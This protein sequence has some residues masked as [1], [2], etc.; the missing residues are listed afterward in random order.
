MGLPEINIEF[1]GKAVSAIL[2]SAMGIVSLILRDDTSTFDS[3]EYK[4]I[5]EIKGNDWSPENTDFIKL[6]MKGTPKKVICE[7]VGTEATDFN[8]AL[9]RLG[10]K[11]WNYLAIPE[12]LSTEVPDIET[13]IKAKRENEK[14]TFKAV[15]PN[16]EADHEGII[17]FATDDIQVGARTY[18]TEEYCARIAGVLAGLPFTRSSTY[19]VLNEVDSVKESDNPDQD[20][21]SGK[22]ILINDG[23]KVKIARGVNSLTSTTIEKTEDFKKIKIL[24]VMEMVTDDIRDTFN[25]SYV[26]KVPNTYDNQVLF[27]I[28]V[29]SYFKGLAGDSILDPSFDN[30]ADVNVSAQRL[31]WEGI[32]TDTTEWDDQKVKNNSFKS[33]VFAA[34]NIKIVDAME[35]LDF[36]IAI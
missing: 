32:G 30:R 20:I 9:A 14:K 3:K 23:E 31:A 5:E 19:F 27:F 25:N 28:S 1:K 2:R 8:A 7:R 16:A 29:N 13:W 21:D 15:L 35:D 11:K 26:G 34:G 4:D 10:S 24:E 12:I 33:T 22:L 36:Q 6:V 18:T 17:N